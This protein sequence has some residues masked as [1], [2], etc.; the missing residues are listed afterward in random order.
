VLSSAAALLDE[1]FEHP[2]ERFLFVGAVLFG[3]IQRYRQGFPQ[4]QPNDEPPK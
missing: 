2:A 4:C 3:D 1:L